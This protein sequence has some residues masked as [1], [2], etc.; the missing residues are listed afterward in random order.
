MRPVH[1]KISATM[2]YVLFD[3]LFNGQQ[4]LGCILALHVQQASTKKPAFREKKPKLRN[5]K[6]A[7][8]LAGPFPK[9]LI[10]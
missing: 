9:A 8:T 7:G 5:R 10:I 2:Y 1:T 6:I 3:A 4:A